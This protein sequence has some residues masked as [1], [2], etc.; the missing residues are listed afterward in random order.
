APLTRI[1]S[2]GGGS[3][4]SVWTQ[5]VSDVT[6]LPQ[7]VISPS[8]AAI[9]AAFVAGYGVGIFTTLAEIGQWHR[10][11]T[12]ITPNLEAHCTYQQMYAIYRSL[13]P[14]TRDAMHALHDLAH[15]RAGSDA[16][17]V[18]KES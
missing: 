8:N 11:F 3:T 12:D 13:Y 7:R 1:L 9:G 2:S 10:T 4:S 5:I 18:S 6:G 16:A 15:H 17:S 14:S